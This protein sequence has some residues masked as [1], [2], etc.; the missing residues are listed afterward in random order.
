MV[1]AA[2][3]LF[4]L[5]P[6]ARAQSLSVLPVNIFFSPGQNATSLTVTNTGDKET[7]I[8][9]RAYSWSQDGEADPLGDTKFITLSP[10]L[11]RIAPGDSQVVRIILRQIPKDQEATYRILIDQVPPPGEAGV[12]HYVLRLSIPIF[13]KPAIRSSANV[14]FHI[15][16]DA[17][18]FYLVA[19]NTGN[20]HE[21]L[22][23]IT[24]TTPDGHKL[25]AE[26]GSLP[27]ILPGSTRRWHIV[28][29]DPMPG[30]IETLRLKAQMSASA[31][32][33]QV[34]FV[35]AH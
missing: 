35:P 14:E 17:G 5:A 10:P 28:A 30:Q 23:D 19:T 31:I 22:R 33:Q 32:D 16:N 3:F 7:T 24:L 25:K 18:Q 8:Q 15:T 6:V 12:V 34:R 2:S 4:F 1:V 29:Q 27:Y 26:S 20:L 13:V 11:A 9:I 21:V